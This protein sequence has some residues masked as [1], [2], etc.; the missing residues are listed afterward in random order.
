[1]ISRP[2]GDQP[3]GISPSAKCQADKRHRHKRA[4]PGRR[5][6][7]SRAESIIAE[8]GLKQGRQRC[9]GGVE[10]RESAKDDDAACSEISLPQG[11]EIDHGAGVAQLPKDQRDQ[12]QNEKNRQRLHTPEWIAQP[13][14]LL[15]LA[16]HHL[17][18][19]HDDH[20]QRQAERVKTQ[21]LLPQLHTLLREIVRIPQQSITRSKRHETHWNVDVEHPSPR[22]AVRD[23]AAERRTD[24]RRQKGSQAKQRHRNALLLDRKGVQQHALTGR[25]KTAARQALH[26]AKHNQLTETCGHP[27][28]RRTRG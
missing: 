12:T 2:R 16:E 1:M 7:Q 10:D 25:L 18:G 4:E 13:V 19:D 3:P 17:P 26:D 9:A 11:T 20:Q 6:D 14:P 24:D 23:P 22:I 8:Q 27:A 5:H 21:R 15:S 28:K